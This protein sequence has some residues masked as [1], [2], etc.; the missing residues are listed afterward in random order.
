MFDHPA[1]FRCRTNC[2]F[3]Y[4]SI[5]SPVDI[6]LT[7]MRLWV[8]NE[9]QACTKAVRYSLLMEINQVCRTHSIMAAAL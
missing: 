7:V 2:L 9:P 4:G 6:E 1:A 8:A 3:D 5:A